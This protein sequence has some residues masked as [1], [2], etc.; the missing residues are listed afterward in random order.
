M[1]ERI[2]IFTIKNKRELFLRAEKPIAKKKAKLTR[3]KLAERNNAKKEKTQTQQ[4]KSNLEI[5]HKKESR[6]AAEA[7]LT[8]QVRSSMHQ[9]HRLAKSIAKSLGLK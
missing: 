8:T 7:K 6:A 2:R 9:K 4:F 1:R 5:L 3:N